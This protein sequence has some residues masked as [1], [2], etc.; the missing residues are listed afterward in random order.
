MG[1]NDRPW[2]HYALGAAGLGA[3]AVGVSKMTKSSSGTP[4]PVSPR[5]PLPSGATVLTSYLSDDFF[6]GPATSTQT[7]LL[8]ME[9]H[10]QSKGSTISAEDLAEIFIAESDCK[11]SKPNS[12]G[13]AGL[14]QICN[15][16]GVNWPG[17]V[18]EYLALPGERQLIFVQRYF[19]NTR[20]GKS[21]PLITD[22][23]S[24]YLTN[25][26]PAFLDPPSSPVW[27]GRFPI[28][29]AASDPHPKKADGTVGPNTYD[30]N[31]GVDTG[32]KGHIDLADM[33]LFVHRQSAGRATKFAELKSR[34]NTARPIV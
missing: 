12:I 23:G 2:W 13:C 21:Y 9:E 33:A 1:V 6:G 14:N 15:L 30:L 5:V 10:F 31:R 4:P 18:Q 26:S 22:V 19:D 7:S 11:P 27:K 29:Y 16:R 8:R 3:A 24:L 28:M 32:R 25:F 20:G 34:I 17:T